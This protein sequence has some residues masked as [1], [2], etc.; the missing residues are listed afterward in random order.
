M[1]TKQHAANL[2]DLIRRNF[3]FPYQED[4][5]AICDEA[6][7]ICSALPS[8]QNVRNVTDLIDTYVD[9]PSDQETWYEIEDALFAL[10]IDAASRER[11]LDFLIENYPDFFEAA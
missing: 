2:C 4:W 9:I 5:Y 8:T 1:S 11:Y 3:D 7:A 6:E 10:V